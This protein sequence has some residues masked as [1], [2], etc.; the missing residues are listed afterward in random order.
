MKKVILIILVSIFALN[1]SKDTSSRNTKVEE[2]EQSTDGGEQSE[3]QDSDNPTTSNTIKIEI[4]GLDE[5]DYSEIQVFTPNGLSE[6]KDDGSF[7]SE[8]KN[9]DIEKLPLIFV[10]DTTLLVGNNAVPVIKRDTRQ[11]HAM[12]TNGSEDQAHRDRFKFARSAGAQTAVFVLVQLVFHQLDR[13]DVIRA[14]QFDWRHQKP[15]HDL[16][17][18]FLDFVLRILFQQLII[19]FRRAIITF[20][21]VLAA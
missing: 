7:E 21:Q 1:C 4:D 12:I 18:F 6:L 16:P 10:D 20:E 17:R 11:R 3:N 19:A 5:I 13:F 15:D 14:Q 2:Q 9:G 8:F